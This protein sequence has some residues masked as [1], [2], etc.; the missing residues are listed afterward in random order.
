M[1]LIVDPQIIPDSRLLVDNVAAGPPCK[2]AVCVRG[3]GVFQRLGCAAIGANRP[4]FR[5]SVL[6]ADK[7]DAL[8][9][10]G[11]CGAGGRGMLKESELDRLATGDRPFEDVCFVGVCPK[12]ER[13]PAPIWRE[14]RFAE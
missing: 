5:C 10:R 12:S 4:H 7:S 3:V 11:P 8:A 6:I 2:F 1:R 9:V 14:T 13:Y